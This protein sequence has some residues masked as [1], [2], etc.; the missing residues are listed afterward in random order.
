MVSIDNN[1]II[2]SWGYGTMIS[3]LILEMAFSI[4][5]TSNIK[6]MLEQRYFRDNG[7]YIILKMGNSKILIKIMN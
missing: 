6:G 2:R 4:E 3:V 7:Q 1:I 5:I